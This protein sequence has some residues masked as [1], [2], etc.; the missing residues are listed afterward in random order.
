MKKKLLLGVALSALLLYL[1][2]RGI[3]FQGVVAGFRTV[4]YGYALLGVAAMLLMQVLRSFRW[5]LILRPLAKIDQWSLFSVSNVGFL[6]IIALPAR[7]GELARP[8]LITK[9]SPLKMSSALGTIFVERILDML[10]V[11]VIAAV[12]LFIIPLPPWLVQGAVL[13]FL[14]TLAM[15]LLV[16]LM[17][18]KRE[19]TLRILSPLIGRLPERYAEG[20][21]RLIRHFLEGFRIMVDPRRLIATLAL[22]IVIWLVDVYAIQM[23]L[24]AF[25]FQLPLAAPFVVMLILVVGIAI[26]TAPGFIGNWHYFCILALGLYSVPKTDALSFAIVYHVLS[27]GVIILLGLVSLPHNRFSISDIRRYSQN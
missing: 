18:V 8:Y 13:V 16:I 20:F 5:G 12:L 7:L 23:M 25:D 26:P 14:V 21:L 11:L 24:A 1:S 22:S 6:A 3:D 4:R 15:A 10:T 27:I 9:K 2:V 19:A 17:I